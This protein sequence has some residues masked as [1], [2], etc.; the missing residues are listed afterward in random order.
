MDFASDW[1]GMP[2]CKATEIT[3]A[4]SASMAL[5]SEPS[6]PAVRNTSQGR[7]SSGSKPTVPVT[8]RPFGWGE[9]AG[10]HRF[11]ADSSSH[12]K[13]HYRANSGPFSNDRNRSSAAPIGEAGTFA[14]GP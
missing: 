8:A 13:W 7:P 1:A 6:L 10:G 5:I 4:A 11:S 14:G 2:C 12:G 9:G 3:T